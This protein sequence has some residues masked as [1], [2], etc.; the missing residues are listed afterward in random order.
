MLNSVPFPGIEPGAA[1]YWSR[2]QQTLCLLFGIDLQ[3]YIHYLEC[4]S[5]VLSK[6]VYSS[7]CMYYKGN[8]NPN[9]GW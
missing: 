5:K 7:L 9:L 8:T 4:L 3:E 6:T 1:N 2:V